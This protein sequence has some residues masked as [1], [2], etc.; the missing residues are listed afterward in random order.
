[1]K[2]DG[3]EEFCIDGETCLLFDQDSEAISEGL[4]AVLQNPSL[5]IRLIDG[6]IATSRMYNWDSVMTNLIKQFGF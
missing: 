4:V 6:G 5:K 1:M 3:N 2:A